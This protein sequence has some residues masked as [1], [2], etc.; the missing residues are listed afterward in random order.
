MNRNLLTKTFKSARHVF[1][2]GLLFFI[3][4]GCAGKGIET[5]IIHRD[6]LNQSVKETYSHELDYIK[7]RRN[8][9][10]IA[11]VA[12]DGKDVIGLAFSGGGIRSATFNLG[13]LQALEQGD[14]LQKIDY[15]STVSGGGYIGAWYVG[16]MLNADE[17]DRFNKN[18]VLMFS[19]DPKKL[20]LSANDEETASWKDADPV[21]HMRGHS[22]FIF[23]NVYTGA[24]GPATWWLARWVPNFIFDFA[25][26]YKPIKGKFDWH[27][28]FYI[29]K[30]KIEKTYIVG[31]YLDDK[32]TYDRILLKDINPTGNKAPYLVINASLRNGFGVVPFEFTRDYCGAPEVGFIPTAGFDK[33]VKKVYFDENGK[34]ERVELLERPW[35][36][37]RKTDEFPLS[38]AVTAS[39]AAVDS[40]GLKHSWIYEPITKFLNLNLRYQTR[41]YSQSLSDWYLWPLDRLREITIDRFYTSPRSNTLKISDGGHYDNL[42]VTALVKRRVPTIIVF[43][44]SADPQYDYSSLDK[45][46]NKLKKQG[47]DLE[48]DKKSKKI[49]TKSNDGKYRPPEYSVLK[50]KIKQNKAANPENRYT[51]DFYYCKASCR[52]KKSPSSYDP[53]PLKLPKYVSEYAKDKKAFP[54]DST[55]IQWY[56]W[57]QYEAYRQ[58]GFCI[59]NLLLKEAGL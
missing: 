24:L 18:S 26:S 15:L 1:L 13:V 11:P 17:E 32:K 33:A 28:P 25:L 37:L 58:L 27:H 23:D 42:G 12:E 35:P 57:S 29:Y 44:A 6:D 31:N 14:K 21:I 59:G 4:Q 52:N 7:A 22:K 34:P 39:G 47:F 20:L 45:T 2:L 50:G 51:A 8:A 19:T 56:K 16:H 55:I 46:T 10:G 5:N 36:I 40:A 48:F 30:K 43:D 54:H 53:T 41:N 49:L 3:F 9:A 38:S